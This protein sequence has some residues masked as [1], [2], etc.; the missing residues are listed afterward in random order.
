VRTLRACAALLIVAG[1][2]IWAYSSLRADPQALEDGT[3]IL[4]LLSN[5]DDSSAQSDGAILELSHARRN[6]RIEFLREALSSEAAAD[7]LRWHEHALAIALSQVDY[8]EA[9]ALYRAAIRPALDRSPQAAALRESFALISRWSLI[10]EIAPDD[11][12]TLS[13]KLVARLAAERSAEIR[14]QLAAAIAELAPRLAQAAAANIA[15]KL[16]A[17]ATSVEPTSIYDPIRALIAIAPQLSPEQRRELAKGLVSRLSVEKNRAF[18]GALAPAL[19]PLSS[20]LDAKT[21]AELATTLAARIVEEFDAR[22]L[23]ALVN[24]FA[25]V[26]ARVD[27]IDAERIATNLV[28]HVKFEPD[29]S[30]LFPITQALA[31]FGDRL[32]RSVYEDAGDGLLK[33]IRSERDVATLSDYALS[34]GALKGK[35]APKQFEAASI[36]IVSRFATEH[37]MQALTALS[38][39]IESVADVLEPSVAERLS[40]LLVARMFA[41]N[42]PGSLLH[43]AEGLESIADEARGAGASALVSRL[44][45]RMAQEK[46]S[47]VLRGLAFSVA[48]FRNAS[49]DFDAAA[50]ILVKRM[51]SEDET[52]DLRRLTSGLYALREKSS[53]RYFERAASILAGRI[54]TQIKP[55][56]VADLVVSLHALAGK[57]TAEP[58]E[59]AV[60]AIVMNP[61]DR[62]AL[63]ASLSRLAGKLRPEATKQITAMLES[64]VARE[65]DPES[66]RIL[67]ASLALLPDHARPLSDLFNPLCP[68]PAWEDLAMQAI[69]HPR[70]NAGEMEPDFAHLAAD[71]DDGDDGPPEEPPL[72]FHQLSDAVR[73]LRPPHANPSISAAFPWAGMGLIAMGGLAL[74]YSLRSRATFNQL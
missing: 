54:E 50:G 55:A 58:F 23:T 45:A 43:I 10:Q 71:D 65:N 2:A 32:P 3:L 63:E 13:S 14:D 6:V 40:L 74:L 47:H 9:T 20:S 8:A 66:R 15:D 7:K 29:P 53:S 27:S 59:R 34:F 16:I 25:G 41:E 31:A 17:I 36:E 11:A 61:N 35:A 57:A 28:Q 24:A 30:V 37:D 33:R 21:A 12:A 39:A 67:N 22:S 72:D 49:G 52:D 1:A 56:E 69:H 18:L 44:T 73:D 60:T 4:G 26:A 5:S 42:H 64:Q 19:P 46:S 62:S 38:G 70:A 68:A 48:A 51:E